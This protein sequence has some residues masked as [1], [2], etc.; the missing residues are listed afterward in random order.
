VLLRQVGDLAS[1]YPARVAYSLDTWR[2]LPSV[3]P[4]FIFNM[5]EE[6]YFNAT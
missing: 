1:N 3:E 5:K 2:I 6:H 4:V